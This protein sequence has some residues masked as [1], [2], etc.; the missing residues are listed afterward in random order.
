MLLVSTKTIPNKRI[1]Y[2]KGVVTS[3]V[4]MSRHIIKDLTAGFKSIVG[5]ELTNYTEMIENANQFI[6]DRFIQQAKQQGANAIVNV[7]F[8]ME[9]VHKNMRTV[10]IMQGLIPLD[11]PIGSVRS[12]IQL[13]G[14]GTLV[15]VE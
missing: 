7:T 13:I 1:I 10:D 8:K 11:I 4:V 9:M 2:E 3:S 5:G 12:H 14:Y 6:Q 15:V